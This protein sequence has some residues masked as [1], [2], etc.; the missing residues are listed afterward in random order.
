MT[1][2][3]TFD[4]VP[5]APRTPD[6]APARIDHVQ[7]AVMYIALLIAVLTAVRDFLIQTGADHAGH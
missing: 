1:V 3:H 6:S 2:P 7:R 5:T 4:D